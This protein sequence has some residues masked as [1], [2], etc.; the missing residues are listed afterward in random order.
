[1]N[2][3][4]ISIK[5][6]V[7]VTMMMAVLVVIGKF[8]YDRLSVD[9]FP[10]TSNP[11]VSISTTYS[12]AGPS[13]VQ[14]Q[15]TQPIEDALS[16]LPGVTNIRSTSRENNSQISVDFTLETDPK[17]AFDIVR[18]R[19]ARTQ[20]SLPS[21]ASQ[22]VVQ[23]F[24]FSSQSVLTFNISDKAGRMKSYELRTLVED[25]L[26]PRI[27]RIDGV[28]DVSVGGGGRREI[29]VNLNLD[30]LRTHRL[31]LAQVSAAIRGENLSVPGGKITQDGTDLLLRV[32]GEFT[33]LDDI[34]NL[35]IVT[36]RGTP[37]RIKDIAT[38]QEATAEVTSYSR[39]NGKDSVSV[40]V[41]KQ[42]GTNT[43]QVAERV[44]AEVQRMQ[45]D[46]RD[47]D[48]VISNDQSSFIKKSIEDSTMDLIYGAGFASLI[49][50]LFFRNLLNTFV[51]IA[52]LP[53]IMIGTFAAMSALGL[54]LNMMTLL[55]LSLAVGLVL[56]DAI[57]VRENI[58]RHME[59]GETPKEAAARGT[60]EVALSVVAMTLTI[61]SV[62]FPIAFT[63]GQIGRFYREFGIAVTAAVMISLFEAFTL[64]PMLS[65][66]L[67][68]QK[69]HKPSE[70]G[71]EETVKQG[72]LDRGYRNLLAWTLDHRLII[73]IVA[74]A[75]LGGLYV[76][77]PGVMQTVSFIPRIDNAN[78]Q[79][80][81]ALP[82]G[83][84]LAVTNAQAKL[85]E[86]QLLT[87]DG[88]DNIFSNVGGGSSPERASFNVQ[89]KDLGRLK[90]IEAEVRQKL[91]GFKGLSYNFQGGFG[92]GGGTNVGSRPIQINLLSNGSP[93]E[94]DLVAQD[95]IKG[96]A[97]VQ[98]LAD[99]DRSNEPGKP[100]LRIVVDRNRASQ[101]NLTTSS[102]G[103]TIRALVSGETA[104]RY[105]EPGK[106]ADIVVRLRPE[107]RSRLDD[108]MSL[109]IQTPSGQMVPLRN[110]AT[111]TSSSGPSVIS[112]LNRQTQIG[113]GANTV[114]RVQALVVA[115]MRERLNQM[116]LPANVTVRF[117]GQVQQTA[118][119]LNTL[120]GSLA[121]S[122]L[123]MYMVLASQ[124][125][126]FTQP[127]VLMLALPLAIIG[128]FGALVI[129][130]TNAD[131]TAVI[132]LILL[133][134]L[135]VKNSILLVDLANRMR[136]QGMTP[137]EALL[138]AGPTRLRPI[139]M[140]T[141]SLILGM[142]PVALARG[143][144]GSFRA[145]MA[146][147]VIG[148]LITSTLLTL[149]IVPV[150]YDMLVTTQDR[151]LRRSTKK[152][153]QAAPTPASE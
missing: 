100:E 22:P 44:R 114:G 42:S 141:A 103:S 13:E 121:L 143:A 106:E 99:I 96:M 131:M 36:S 153:T 7:F 41:R 4:N 125:G 87:V 82:P 105:R 54:S 102:M 85:I 11:S 113:I 83:T 3:A 115:D 37:L 39:L 101:Y 86:E 108:I 107:D 97:G 40:Q 140:T 49:V 73:F 59:R 133:M 149:L 152:V 81:L 58:F 32:P 95:I 65:A 80:G 28:A 63:T 146:I 84:T 5:Q 25:Q 45:R 10:D 75:I 71:E 48:I 104:S 9:L 69:K 150:F 124:F 64:A 122:V 112:R 119:A 109:N 20:N 145:P 53:V 94:L 135:A 72:W 151:L 134:G 33:A 14:R 138:V 147:A 123:F 52:G 68:R 117:G 89:M 55:A 88:I 8:G 78:F 27:E 127:I 51:T 144:G 91:G 90:A 92:G 15:V 93:E 31:T 19:V 148:G 18:E 139:L 61:A 66:Y 30:D 24:D 34:A 2:L 29:Q 23:R 116:R 1:M 126:S 56:D 60:N 110:L 50:L 17:A 12:G 43:V 137:V 130:G 79:V 67:F 47:L 77:V 76:I 26:Q 128:A 38:V 111:V 98:G 46:F 136:A 6:P 74:L 62:F 120:I 70:T 132:G 21:G 118:D 35:T 129:T 16:T 142:T 57:V